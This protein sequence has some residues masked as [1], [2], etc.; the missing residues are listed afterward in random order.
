M[1]KRVILAALVAGWLLSFPLQ[2][3][4]AEVI[5]YVGHLNNL[6]SLPKTKTIPQPFDLN[7]TTILMSTGGVATPQ[8]TGVV[9]FENRTQ[10]PVTIERGLRVMGGDTSFQ[11]WETFLPIQRTPGKNLVLADTGD[12][13]IGQYNFDTSNAG[14]GTAPI[15]KD[16]VNGVA[17]EF[18]D[19]AGVL[20][21]HADAGGNQ[22]TAPY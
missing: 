2:R 14:N 21:G 5:G 10:D 1:Q 20:L 7:T 8:D 15:V 4:S 11:I 18:R 13:A 16:S 22:E 12:P 3:V 19:Q 6:S 17:F 9:R